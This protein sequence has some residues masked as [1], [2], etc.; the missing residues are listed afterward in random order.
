MFL[1]LFKG[2]STFIHRNFHNFVTGLPGR[3]GSTET[4]PA[5]LRE[6]FPNKES[7]LLRR[8]LK[9]VI[10][11]PPK[12]ESAKGTSHEA[13]RRGYLRGTPFLKLLRG[14]PTSEQ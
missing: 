5:G 10:G 4:A 14:Q 6:P 2:G 8:L 7:R 12:L 9:N 11:L 1:P 3:L 13:A